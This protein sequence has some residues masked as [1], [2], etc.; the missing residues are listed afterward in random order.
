MKECLIGKSFEEIKEIVSS[1]G[2]ASFRAK[3]IFEGIN[4]GK[5]IDEISNISKALKEK[6]NEKYVGIPVEIY[7]KLVK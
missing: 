4:K 5:Q 6:L 2:E 1:L 3:Q 7:K